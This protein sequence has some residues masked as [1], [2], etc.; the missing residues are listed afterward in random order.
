MLD[1]FEHRVHVNGRQCAQVHDLAVDAFLAQRFGRGQRARRHQPVGH[2]GHVAP[3]ARDVRLAKRDRIRLFR[4]LRLRIVEALVFQEDHRVV[5]AD[6]LDQQPLAVV[7]VR[8]ADHLHAGD[9]REDRGQHLAVLRRRA[10]TRAA[11]GPDHHRRLCLAAEHIA[12]LGRLVVDLVEADAHEID[13]HQFR[14]RAQAAGRGP[15]RGAHI[16]AFRQRRVDHL[17]GVLVVE[18]LRDAEH[19]APGVFLAAR[20]GPAGDVFAEHNHRAVTGHF[21]IDRFVDRVFHAD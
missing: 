15:D 16:G 14:D 4:D 18:P 10:E 3:F 6:G 17:P 8:G 1:A 2:E 11:H 21:L 9:V 7:G 5:V 20:A 13:E 12:E 19:A